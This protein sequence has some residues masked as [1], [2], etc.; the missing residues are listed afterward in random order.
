MEIIGL[1]IKKKIRKTW[2]VLLNVW[3]YFSMIEHI[4][5]ASWMAKEAVHLWSVSR[6]KLI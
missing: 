5:G 4:C 1:K 6:L 2:S 3:V